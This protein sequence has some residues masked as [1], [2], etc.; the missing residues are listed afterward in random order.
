MKATAPK[1]APEKA[2]EGK[3]KR[4]FMYALSFAYNILQVRRPTTWGVAQT[5]GGAGGGSVVV[6]SS[7]S[8]AS[9]LASSGCR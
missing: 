2:V 1:K 7:S 6:A 3:E 9:C 4:D 8:S 5:T